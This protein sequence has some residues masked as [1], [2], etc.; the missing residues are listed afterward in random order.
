MGDSRGELRHG[1]KPYPND[2]DAWMMGLTVWQRRPEERAAESEDGGRD[3]AAK[4]HAKGH[5]NGHAADRKA[6]L[7]GRK[8]YEPADAL[9]SRL[10]SVG[11]MW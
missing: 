9:R 5:A 7:P 8:Q 10:T 11:F 4:G 1:H 2:F 6:V 3:T